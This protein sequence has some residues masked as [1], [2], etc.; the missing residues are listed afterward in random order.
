M[1]WCPLFQ[2]RALVAQG[3]DMN[4]VGENGITA[5]HIAAFM[6]HVEVLRN[7]DVPHSGAVWRPASEAQAVTLV[8]PRIRRC[9]RTSARPVPTSTQAAE[10]TALS[11]RRCERLDQLASQPGSHTLTP[12]P[13]HRRQNTPAYLH[14]TRSTSEAHAA[15]S[16][17]QAGESE[18]HDA[19]A[20]VLVEH[21]A[22]L[23]Q[24][25][26]SPLHRACAVGAL[27]CLGAMAA[28]GCPVP[29]LR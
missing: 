1:C 3:I 13:V 23:P 27:H 28:K 10:A 25:G 14:S 2:V 9:Y 6:G 16:I 19:S 29:C 11:T 26:F 7:S 15:P 5:A 24:Q 4:I 20:A 8:S 12:T 18:R 22:A 17:P 21:G